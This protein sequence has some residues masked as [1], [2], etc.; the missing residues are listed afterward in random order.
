MSTTTHHRAGRARRWFGVPRWIWLAGVVGLLVFVA[1]YGPWSQPSARVATIVDGLR[2]SSVYRQPGAPDLVNPARVRQVIGDRPIVVAILDRTPLPAGSDSDDPREALCQQVAK[3]I[4]N[5]YIWIYGADSTGKYSGNDCYGSDFPTPTAKG[6][7][8]FDFDAG[9][10]ISAQ[11]SAQFRTSPTNL[12]PELEEFVLSFDAETAKDYGAVPTRGAIPDALA[13]RQLTLAA[14]G[15]VAGTVTLFLLL[16]LLGLAIR[17]RSGAAAARATRHAELS[18]RLN[19]VADAVINPRPHATAE[20][21]AHQ[22]TVAKRYVLALDQL[23]HA[24]TDDELGTAAHEIDAL[25]RQ[26]HQ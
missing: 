18:T 7:D 16:R 1:V 12:T 24:H 15:L 5:D 23:D 22:A 21:A 11:L 6:V 9:V 14:L 10:N 25:V 8:M 4:T 26:V 19:E 17:G 13:T 20:Q 3:Q 2:T